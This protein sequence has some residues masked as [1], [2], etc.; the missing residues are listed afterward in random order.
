MA[1]G[2]PH[3]C[4]DPVPQRPAAREPCRSQRPRRPCNSTGSQPRQGPRRGSQAAPPQRAGRK[5]SGSD[6]V[7]QERPQAR[8]RVP[9]N[10]WARATAWGDEAAVTC[11]SVP[12]LTSATV[13]VFVFCVFLFCLF[14]TSATGAETRAAPTEAS[15]ATSTNFS[16][17]FWATFWPKLAPGPL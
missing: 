1:A 6:R 4:R 15:A 13:C 2:P 11:E 16:F 3:A 17:G 8:C 5:R 10:A 12:A 9:R 14:L 7:K